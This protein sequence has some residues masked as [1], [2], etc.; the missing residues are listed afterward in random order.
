MLSTLSTLYSQKNGSTT[1][2]INL[3]SKLYWLI[4]I[5]NTF[6]LTNMINWI[7]HFLNR[8]ISICYHAVV[9]PAFYIKENLKG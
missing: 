3:I 1:A 7:Q 5:V 4:L 9:I 2:A 8:D 6:W